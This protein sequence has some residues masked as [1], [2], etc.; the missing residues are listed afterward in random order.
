MEYDVTTKNDTVFV[1]AQSFYKAWHAKV[2][3]KPTPLLRANYAFQAV[4]VPAR[5][6]TIVFE[7]RDD[8]FRVGMAATILTFLAG[9]ALWFAF[10][11]KNRIAP[12]A[13]P[14]TA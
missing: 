11:P 14:T 7:Y 8:A 9:V 4:A 10:K 6:K 1:L 2:D 5:A 12:D 3:G 13:Q